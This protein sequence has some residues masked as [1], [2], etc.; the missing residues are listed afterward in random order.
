VSKFA[1]LPLCS[2]GLAVPQTA[3]VTVDNESGMAQVVRHLVEHHGA[4][5][6]AFISGPT[7]NAESE[8]RVAAYRAVLKATES[9]WTNSC[10]SPGNFTMDSGAQAVRNLAKRFGARLEQLDALVAANDNMA[11]GA[12]DELESMGISVPDELAVLGFDDIEEARLTEPSLTGALADA[13]G[14]AIRNFAKS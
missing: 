9:R 13:I 1:G 6:V 11:I 3:S 2:V 4:K 7:A 12:L 14:I 8:L 5:Q 10:C